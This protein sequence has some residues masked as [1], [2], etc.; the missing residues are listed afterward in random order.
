LDGHRD[1]V[2]QEDPPFALSIISIKELTFKK[3]LNN[4]RIIVV[5]ASDTGLSFIESLLTLKEVRFT[6]LTLLAPGGLLTMNV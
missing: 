1:P 6:N 3:T 2:D 5:G 4:T